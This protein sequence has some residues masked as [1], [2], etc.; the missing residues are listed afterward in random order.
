MGKEM[1]SHI[2]SSLGSGVRKQRDPTKQDLC[3]S[4]AELGSFS[5]SCYSSAKLEMGWKDADPI[6]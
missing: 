2:I 6:P 5:L 1:P 4:E 3:L